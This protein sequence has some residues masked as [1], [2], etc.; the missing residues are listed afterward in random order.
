MLKQNTFI[1]KMLKAGPTASVEDLYH[2]HETD[3]KKS[4]VLT[5]V[6]IEEL[7]LMGEATTYQHAISRE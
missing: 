5:R 3:I 2:K 1:A 6:I 7:Y 4:G